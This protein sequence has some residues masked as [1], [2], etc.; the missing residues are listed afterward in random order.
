ME[1]VIAAYDEGGRVS[2]DEMVYIILGLIAAGTDTVMNILSRMTL[3]L[4]REDRRLWDQVAAQVAA[5]GEVTRVVLDELLRLVQQGNGAM[6]RVAEQDV[7]LPSGTI[8]AGE[9]LALPLSSAGLDN[10]VFP[11]PHTLRFDRQ[12]PRSLIFGG[13]PHYCVGVNVAKAELQLGLQALMTRLPGMRLAGDPAG[14]TFTKGEL[15][16]V[17]TSVPVTW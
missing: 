9:T 8:R 13:G 10:E 2:E 12:G 11:E 3:M 16:T 7:E 6:L 1:L 5:Q 4:L 17:L 15:L 14:L